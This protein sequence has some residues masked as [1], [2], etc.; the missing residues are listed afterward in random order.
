M[1]FKT[2]WSEV[3]SFSLDGTNTEH[4]SIFEVLIYDSDLLIKWYIKNSLYSFIGCSEAIKTIFME[5]NNTN[6]MERQTKLAKFTFLSFETHCK[7][8][9]INY[10]LRRI[11]NHTNYCL[12]NMSN[13][14]TIP[15]LSRA[16]F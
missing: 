8:S 9:A 13:R 16:S 2:L 15:E 1:S 7:I 11:I 5:L 3:D 4:S 12:V 6:Q 10:L 14:M